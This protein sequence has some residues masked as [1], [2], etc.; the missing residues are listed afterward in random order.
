MPER[1]KAHGGMCRA[2][3]ALCLASSVSL[4]A[5]M[6]AWAQTSAK[7][8][9][10]Q[11]IVIRILEAHSGKPINKEPLGVRL[12]KGITL[13]K[14]PVTAP[15]FVTDK[16][17]NAV[18]PYRPSVGIDD[19][20]LWVLKDIPCEPYNNVDYKLDYPIAKILAHGVVSDN[21]C[22]KAHHVA[23]PGVLIV[24]VKHHPWWQIP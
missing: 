11:R 19:L 18:I 10:P 23:V 22:G 15:V 2:S 24:F 1:L 12:E 3:A 6:G 17:G 7:P 8:P 16:A 9:V 4:L 14:S 21:V 20:S 5:R 13:T